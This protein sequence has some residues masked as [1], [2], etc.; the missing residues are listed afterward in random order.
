MQENAI[1]IIGVGYVGLP[2]ALSLAKFH[3]RVFGYDLDSKRVSELNSGFDRNDNICNVVP[4]N[5]SFTEELVTIKEATTYIITVPTPIDEKRLPDLNPLRQACR[6]IAQV[7]SKG[8]LVI[9][10]S[11]VYP[12]VTEDIC[13]PLIQE[14][15]GLKQGKEFFLGYSPERINPG[16]DKN[17]LETVIKVVA[18][19]DDKTLNRIKQIYEPVV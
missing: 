8:D 6:D 14:E 7:I 15:S 17:T 19:Q 18:A 1:A 13:G 2:L 9:V 16:D 4:S 3:P 12:G 5:L 10:E 11:T